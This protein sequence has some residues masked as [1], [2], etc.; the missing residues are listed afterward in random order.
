MADKSISITRRPG[1]VVVVAIFLFVA[2]VVAL[3]T[4]VSLLFP[5]PFWNR[6]WDLNRPAYLAFEKF[7][8]LP[9]VLLLALG[10]T[11]GLAGAGLLRGKKW[12]WWIALA[13]FAINGLGDVVTLLLTRDVVRGGSGI[14]IAG[15]F[16]FF[17]T[18]PRVQRYFEEDARD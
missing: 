13:V 7:G 1:T 6:L 17:L 8:K 4:A 3:A 12:A 9:G 10:I 15:V 2:A 11:T 14:L 18:R 16:L 5:S